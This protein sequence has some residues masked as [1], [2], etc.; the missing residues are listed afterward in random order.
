V[1]ISEKARYL[2][3]LV[4]VLEYNTELSTTAFSPVFLS[5]SL[6]RWTIPEKESYCQYERLMASVIWQRMRREERRRR[7]IEFRTFHLPW[8]FNSPGRRNHLS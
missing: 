7:T 5:I 6:R 1:R 2:H 8:A 4:E 3:S